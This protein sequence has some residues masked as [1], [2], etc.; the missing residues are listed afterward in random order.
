M[1]N[2]K[3]HAITS[4]L[5]NEPYS[6]F[7]LVYLPDGQRTIKVITHFDDLQLESAEQDKDNCEVFI[8]YDILIDPN[9]L[10]T[11]VEMCNKGKMYLCCKAGFL[12]YRITTNNICR[13]V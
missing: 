9:D 12:N 6:S 4:H 5:D 11:G 13:T 3:I 8:D 10:V 7:D 1:I 2:R